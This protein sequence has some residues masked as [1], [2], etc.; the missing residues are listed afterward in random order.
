MLGPANNSGPNNSRQYQQD[1]HVVG[2][3]KDEAQRNQRPILFAEEKDYRNYQINNG[4]GRRLCHVETVEKWCGATQQR[5][6]P[7]ER[8]TNSI[9]HQQPVTGEDCQAPEDSRGE[10]CAWPKIAKPG[11]WHLEEV[12]KQVMIDVVFWIES[13]K[14]QP[15]KLRWKTSAAQRFPKQAAPLDVIVTIKIS[16]TNCRG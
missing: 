14:R 1:K 11:E 13:G 5:Q 10:L 16:A 2:Q 3:S 12:E 4:E 15:G 6:E 8:V 9:T 7:D